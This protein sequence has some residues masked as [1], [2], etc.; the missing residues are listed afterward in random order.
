[1]ARNSGSYSTGKRVSNGQSC[2]ESNEDGDS[3]RNCQNDSSSN[4]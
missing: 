3:D 1:M 4:R 2:G